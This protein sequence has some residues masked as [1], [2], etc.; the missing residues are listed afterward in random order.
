M[1]FMH[2]FFALLAN[3]FF[4]VLKVVLVVAAMAFP[5]SQHVFCGLLRGRRGLIFF[6]VI[7][8]GS[9]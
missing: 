3:D 5:K 2:D 9:D 7:A 1:H 4:F 6:F 8:D